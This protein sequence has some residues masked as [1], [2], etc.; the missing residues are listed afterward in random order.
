MEL[1]WK[2]MTWKLSVPSIIRYFFNLASA[3]E[4]TRSSTSISFKKNV[5]FG[6]SANI[7]S[8]K[9]LKSV[10]L[11]TLP[12][13]P[14][15]WR[16]EDFANPSTWLTSPLPCPVTLN[17]RM[18]G[19]PIMLQIFWIL[20]KCWA[21]LYCEEHLP[22]SMMQLW[23]MFFTVWSSLFLAF[24]WGRVTNVW[25]CFFCCCPTRCGGNF[26]RREVLQPSMYRMPSMQSLW[27][28][29]FWKF[30]VFTEIDINETNYQT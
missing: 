9:S 21:D 1:D 20:S 18:M 16:V 11:R 3:S 30:K 24:L 26:F 14:T 23:G 17:S 22:L 15:Y 19:T 28:E 5:G 12:P 7:V 27:L 10:A 4:S 6:F 2:T 29:F 13:A 8:R 25:S